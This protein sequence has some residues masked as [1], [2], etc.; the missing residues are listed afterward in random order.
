LQQD[1]QWDKVFQSCLSFPMNEVIVKFR[2]D[3]DMVEDFETTFLEISN[4]EWKNDIEFQES[5]KKVYVTFQSEIQRDD[6]EAIVLFDLFKNHVFE[7]TSM[8]T[9]E[10]RIVPCYYISTFE[11]ILWTW[12]H[13]SSV[14]GK[15]KQHP[16]NKLLEG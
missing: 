4:S 8:G 9:L 2:S 1:F 5:N 10:C 12:T 14:I 16:S 7:N 3:L 15:T 6:E 13:S 11:R